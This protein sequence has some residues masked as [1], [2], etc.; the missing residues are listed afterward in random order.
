MQHN[1]LQG[2]DQYK[3]MYQSMLQSGWKGVSTVINGSGLKFVY[4]VIDRK[5]G[6]E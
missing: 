6:S 1:E 4:F 2:N 3:R 5:K